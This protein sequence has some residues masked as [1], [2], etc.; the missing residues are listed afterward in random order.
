ME[1]Q[2]KVMIR[3]TTIL[4]IK[5][6]GKIAFAADGQVTFANSVILKHGARKMRR[7]YKDQILVAFAG[8]T[9]DSFTLFEKFEEKLEK[10]NGQLL[11]SAVELSKEWRTDKYL[12]RL[13]ALMIVGDRENIYL[14]SGNGDVIESDD[15]ILATGSGGMFANAAAKAMIKHS[16]LGALDIA[17]ESLRIASEICVFTN[18]NIIAEE[19]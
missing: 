15:G 4:A 3:G 19:V 13:E 17:K 6:G 16:K 7:L 18:S 14:L 1:G 2:G 10:Y 12:R 8:S 9:A 5:H 11:R